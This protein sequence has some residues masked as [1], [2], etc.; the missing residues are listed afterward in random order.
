MHVV[1]IWLSAWAL[2]WLVAFPLLMVLPLVRW[3]T[4]LLVE[5]PRNSW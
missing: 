1:S 3:L 5:T 4:A 2:P